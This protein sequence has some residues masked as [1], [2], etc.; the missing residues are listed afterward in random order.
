[1][2]LENL[3]HA[4]CK[5]RDELQRADYGSALSRVDFILYALSF[6]GFVS[7]DGAESVA[8]IVAQYEQKDHA[9]A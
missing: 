6:H 8:S 7:H 3:T 9:R 1:M 5:A 4:L 2:K